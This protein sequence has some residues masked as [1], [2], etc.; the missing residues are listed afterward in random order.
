MVRVPPDKYGTR[1]KQLSRSTALRLSVGAL[2][3]GTVCDT[4][5]SARTPNFRSRPVRQDICAPQDF[6]ALVEQRFR[7]EWWCSKRHNILHIIGDT[8]CCSTSLL[9]QSSFLQSL[10]A[11]FTLLLYLL[12]IA[13]RRTQHLQGTCPQGWR[14]CHCRQSV[15]APLSRLVHQDVAQHFKQMSMSADARV[16]IRRPRR[17]ELR[18][19]TT[20]DTHRDLLLQ[21]A[22]HCSISECTCRCARLCQGL[23]SPGLP[24]VEERATKCKRWHARFRRRLRKGVQRDPKWGRWLPED[25]ISLDQVSTA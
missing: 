10:H 21:I 8:C 12:N 7:C 19:T 2:V 20:N 6:Q 15:G 3:I 18:P 13:S 14:R 5:H 17:V 1:R 11:N 23:H 4:H 16:Y 9:L 22:C 25:R 24:S